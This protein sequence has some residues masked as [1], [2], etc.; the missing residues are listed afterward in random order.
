MN[1]G[2]ARTATL[3]TAGT[4]ILISNLVLKPS[5]RA[6][7]YAARQHTSPSSTVTRIVEVPED[8]YVAKD[9]TRKEFVAECAEWEVTLPLR[10]ST[11]Q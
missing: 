2:F 1:E 9:R 11:G 5:Y 7:R 6:L 10:V 8:Y 4:F 3:G